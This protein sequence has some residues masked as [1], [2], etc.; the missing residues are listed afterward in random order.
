MYIIAVRAYRLSVKESGREM[1]GG[2]MRER[3]MVYFRLEY[4]IVYFHLIV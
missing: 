1:E 4:R 3:D 2:K